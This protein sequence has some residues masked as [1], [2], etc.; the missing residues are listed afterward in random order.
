MNFSIFVWKLKC[1][2][3]SKKNKI[4][5]KASAAYFNAK[6]DIPQIHAKQ[7]GR[8]VKLVTIGQLSAS[9]AP[10]KSLSE[11]STHNRCK[12]PARPQSCVPSESDPS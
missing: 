8:Q 3:F 10:E 5:R 12:P 6:A 11:E 4:K 7:Q 9:S 2:I 1:I